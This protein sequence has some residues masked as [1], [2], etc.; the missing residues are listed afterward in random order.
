M[1]LELYQKKTDEIWCTITADL[2]NGCLSVSGHDLGPQVEEFFPGGEYE[3][4]VSLDRENTRMLFKTLGFSNLDA[5]G[6]LLAIKETFENSTAT[7]ALMNYCKEQGIEAKF[8]CW[9]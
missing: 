3:Y 7:S 4:S 5:E 2:S 9:P 1:K 6:K 8:W